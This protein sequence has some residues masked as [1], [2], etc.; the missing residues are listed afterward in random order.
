MRITDAGIIGESLTDWK[1]RLEGIFRTALGNDLNLDPETPQGQLIGILALTLAQTDEVAVAIANGRSVS[2]AVGRQQEDIASLVSIA[3]RDGER[4]QVTATITGTAGSE[5]PTGMVARTEP[6]GDDFRTTASAIIPAGG[7]V[8][9]VMES[10]DIGKVNAPAG[11]LTRLVTLP[12]GIETITNASASTGGRAKETDEEFRARYQNAIAR[13]GT[14]YAEAIKSAILEKSGVTDVAV[15]DN[16]TNAT[17]T[18]Q[19]VNI[20]AHEAR[21]IVDGGQAADI[22]EAIAESKPI[23]IGTSG[24]TSHTLNGSTY[25]WDAVQNVRLVIAIQIRVRQGFP[26]DGVAQI[27]QNI[28]DWTQGEFDPTDMMAFDTSGLEIG[29]RISTE[30]LRSPINAVVGHEIVSL[31]VQQ[32]N[33]QGNA[34]ALTD[35]NLNQRQTIAAD[36]ISITITS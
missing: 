34:V 17:V 7:S 20:G 33:S 27:K 15:F 6:G 26:S 23:G 9:V 10:V 4:S 12:G 30:R 3:R 8:S 35:P 31:S 36:D 13:I 14:G 25:R 19:G 18:R 28:V 21:I 32:T 5:V 1:T 11:S 24:G 29:E 2:R 16:D 22:A